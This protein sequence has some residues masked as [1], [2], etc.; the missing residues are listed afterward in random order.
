MNYAKYCRSINHALLQLGS[1]Y[2]GDCNGE[3]QK[4]CHVTVWIHWQTFT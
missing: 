3:V 2:G 1:E 4:Q